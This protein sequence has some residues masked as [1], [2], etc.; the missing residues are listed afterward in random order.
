MLKNRVF[1]PLLVITILIF[2]FALLKMTTDTPPTVKKIYRVTTPDAKTPSSPNAETQAETALHNDT[3]PMD[4]EAN[5]EN[6]VAG[7]KDFF[8]GSK[9]AKRVQQ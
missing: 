5:M 3:A 2:G 6:L 8:R 9:D 4:I 7:N 1:Y